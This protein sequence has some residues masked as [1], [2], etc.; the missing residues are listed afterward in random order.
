MRL[1]PQASFPHSTIS[2]TETHNPCALPPAPPSPP[3]T[4]S[5]PSS[6]PLRPPRKAPT[7]SGASS[8][9]SPP[10]TDS[11]PFFVEDARFV[12]LFT[13][14]DAVLRTP[15]GTRV[16]IVTACGVFVARTPLLVS[17]HAA[18]GRV[19]MK[20]ADIRSS[21]GL[22]DVLRGVLQGS[23]DVEG[24]GGEAVAVLTELG[25]KAVDA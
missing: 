19:A 5:G 24:E 6:W 14:A 23:V 16:G 11:N 25:R 2:T 3:P 1:P 22:S 17:L 20:R 18:G 9:T 4:R 21:A 15:D 13:H 10:K 8:P 7:P 12:C